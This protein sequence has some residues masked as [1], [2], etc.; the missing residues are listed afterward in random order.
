MALGFKRGLYVN[1]KA[2][3]TRG[4]ITVRAVATEAGEFLSLP[5]QTSLAIPH[6]F[7]EN[8]SPAASCCPHAG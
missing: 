5:L 3:G 7:P 8:M 4:G 2:L 6:G 1:T